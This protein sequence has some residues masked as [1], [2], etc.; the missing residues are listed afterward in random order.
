MATHGKKNKEYCEI[1]VKDVNVVN[2]NKKN[3]NAWSIHKLGFLH[4]ANKMSTTKELSGIKIMV[5]L[6]TKR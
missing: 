3:T 1:I 2:Q 4:D 5:I 6:R